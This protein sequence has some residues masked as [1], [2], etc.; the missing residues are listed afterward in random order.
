MERFQRGPAWVQ[1]K[2]SQG[3]EIRMLGSMVASPLI[4]CVPSTR[5]EHTWN[6]LEISN[7]RN[8]FQS[9]HF[10]LFSGYPA[11]LKCNDGDPYL[12]HLTCDLRSGISLNRWFL[13]NFGKHL[14]NSPGP[15][16]IGIG[17]DEFF[18]FSSFFARL[19]RRP[20][21]TGIFSAQHEEASWGRLVG[22]KCGGLRQTALMIQIHSSAKNTDYG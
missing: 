4:L 10:G 14:Q 22:T 17:S 15:L 11:V 2:G 12:M 3:E 16:E 7:T 19:L 13:L 6:R 1:R 9:Y 20:F 21:K 18:K 5:W 8:D